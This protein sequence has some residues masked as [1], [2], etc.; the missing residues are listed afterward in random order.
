V[1]TSSCPSL[2]EIPF[3]EKQKGFAVFTEWLKLHAPECRHGDM[4]EF[5][6][7]VA[8]GTGV[9]AAKDLDDG[10]HFMSIPRKAMMTSE[11]F[12]FSPC[13]AALKVRVPFS[14][15]TMRVNMCVRGAPTF[16]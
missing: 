1:Q 8:E 5:D 11:T 12:S 6:V 9:V 3:E 10:A 4:F 13:G 2:S 14:Q 7:D 16:I 15:C